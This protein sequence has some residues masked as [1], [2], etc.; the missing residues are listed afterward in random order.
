[1]FNDFVT[2][3]RLSIISVSI[4]LF[5]LEFLFIL[6]EI[7]KYWVS[8]ISSLISKR[9]LAFR[10]EEYSWLMSVDE[11]QKYEEKQIEFDKKK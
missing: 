4:K 8:S 5:V 6:P 3:L 1:M 9:E 10:E 2:I 7:K 11:V